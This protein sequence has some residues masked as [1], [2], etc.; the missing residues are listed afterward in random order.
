MRPTIS[1]SKL[2]QLAKKVNKR[3]KPKNVLTNEFID[4]VN[5]L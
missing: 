2:V 5:N 3:S 4:A 1:A